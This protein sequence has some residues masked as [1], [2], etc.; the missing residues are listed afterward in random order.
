LDEAKRQQNFARHGIDLA[1]CEVIF[2]AP[3]LTIEDKSEDYGEN[4]CK[5]LACLRCRRVH[6]G[7]T[8]LPRHT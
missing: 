3:M 8:V 2:D 1:H 5:V 4:D 7:L 6:G